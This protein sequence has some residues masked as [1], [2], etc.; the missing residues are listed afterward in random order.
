MIWVTPDYSGY[1]TWTWMYDGVY[2]EWGWN[3]WFGTWGWHWGGWKWSWFWGW[4]F[5]WG[6]SHLVY[7]YVDNVDFGRWT[8][9]W[10]GAGWHWGWNL[11]DG[12]YGW[13]WGGWFWTEA[14]G[15]HYQWLSWAIVYVT[16]DGYHPTW[17]AMYAASHPLNENGYWTWSW[18]WDGEFWELDH[19]AWWGSEAWHWMGWKL[20][21]SGA[22]IIEWGW[23]HAEYVFVNCV[24]GT[25]GYWTW[26]WQ[27]DGEFWEYG[28]HAWWGTEAWHWMG[29]HLT[30]GGAWVIEWG[31]WHAVYVWVN[32]P[33]PSTTST[34]TCDN[35]DLNGDEAT[36]ILDVV[37]TV[38]LILYEEDGQ[39]DAD[40]CQPGDLNLDGETDILDVVEMVS[41]I[42]YE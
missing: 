20:T 27:W 37:A 2:G 10:D 39:L 18:V 22:W 24:T 6:L 15:W 9:V 42:L 29:W 38:N 36:D 21:D 16:E 8:W 13:H 23:W 40:G 41:Y 7:A 17:W 5:E 26:S 33:T 34:V 19:H 32:G 4:H 3:A 14:W 11:W 30:T 28:H 25:C 35:S 31:W 1:W 12:T